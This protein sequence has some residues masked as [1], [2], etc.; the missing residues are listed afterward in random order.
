MPDYFS[1]SA[2]T[3]HKQPKLNRNMHSDTASLVSMRKY[4]RIIAERAPNIIP[5]VSDK[6][7]SKKKSKIIRKP[8][9]AFISSSF[10]LT[11]ELKIMILYSSFQQYIF[12][13]LPFWALCIM[14]VQQVQVTGHKS[15]DSSV[16]FAVFFD[17][18]IFYSPHILFIEVECQL[19]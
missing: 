12:F 4:L 3:Q 1:V 9:D 18:L 7:E 8:V 10:R 2:D 13:I 14:Q 16:F 11:T 19:L 6:N 15:Q 17:L 5:I